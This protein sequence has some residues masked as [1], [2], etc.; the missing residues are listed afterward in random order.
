MTQRQNAT[1]RAIARIAGN[2]TYTLFIEAATNKIFILDLAVPEN[3]SIQSVTLK[4]LSGTVTVNVQ[5]VVIGVTTSVT[6]VSAV[7]VTSVVQTIVPTVD[8][9]ETL[10][11]GST[12]QITTSAGAA[13]VDLSVSV[14]YIKISGNQ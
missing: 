4:T 13:P 12:L 6:G 7:A 9:S 2:D 10:P 8:G 1:Q 14:N 5:K 11:S 3:M